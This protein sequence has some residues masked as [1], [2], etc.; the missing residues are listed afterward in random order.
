MNMCFAKSVGD[1]NVN[2]KVIF[3]DENKEPLPT[4]KEITKQND[5]TDYESKIVMKQIQR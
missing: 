2:C 5:T 4:G 3:D 1:K